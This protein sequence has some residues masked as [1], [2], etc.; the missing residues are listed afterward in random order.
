MR[1]LALAH[2]L[3]SH[4]SK[5]TKGSYKPWFL[6]SRLHGALKPEC[7]ILLFIWSL[8]PLYLKETNILHMSHGQNQVKQA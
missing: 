6:A 8:W 5:T 4:K 1:S 3:R 2:I 7:E